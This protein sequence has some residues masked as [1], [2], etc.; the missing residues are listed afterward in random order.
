MLNTKPPECKIR[1][2]G[3]SF[4]AACG[5]CIGGMVCGEGI[6]AAIRAVSAAAVSEIVYDPSGLE[7]FLFEVRQYAA[8]ETA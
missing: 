7:P 1:C 5:W 2:F 4:F 3:V 8:L 6:S